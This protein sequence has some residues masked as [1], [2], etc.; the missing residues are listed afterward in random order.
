MIVHVK[1][2]SCAPVLWHIVVNRISQLLLLLMLFIFLDFLVSLKVHQFRFDG[3]KREG[4]QMSY[5]N[6][7]I[8]LFQTQQG[9][10]SKY[11]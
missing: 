4:Q 7:S 3:L 2:H 5:F 1:Y 11:M 10:Y 9:T 6:F 8:T